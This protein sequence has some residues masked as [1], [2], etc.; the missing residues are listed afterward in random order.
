MFIFILY[1]ASQFSTQYKDFL[2]SP[3]SESLF[4][5]LTRGN[6]SI[7]DFANDPIVLWFWRSNTGNPEVDSLLKKIHME[8][9]F[10][11]SAVLRWEAKETNDYETKLNKL[12]LAAYLDPSAIENFL[13]YIVLAAEYRKFD[14][15]QTAFSLPVFSDLR[16]QLFIITNAVLL[17]L[18][19]IFM[20]GVVYILAKMVYYLRVL[21]HRI[22]PLNHNRIKGLLAFLI[23][24]IP[25]LVLRHLYLIFVCYSIVLIFVFNSKE[26][27]WLR[28]NII[29]LLLVSVFA[30]PLVPFISFLKKYDRNYQLYEIVRYDSDIT[31][32]ADNHDEKKLLAYGLKRRGEFEKAL[33]LYEDLYYGNMQDFDVTNNLAN[34][35]FLYDENALAETLYLNALRLQ[36]RGEP[37][38]N[39]GLLK[40]KNI[41]Y[42]E[43][44]K[45]MEEARKRNFSSPLKEPVDITPRNADLYKIIRSKDFKLFGIV[46]PIYL[47]P[48]LIILFLTFLP[49]AFSRPFYCKACDRPICEKC[50][51]EIEG[52][53]L[54]EDCFKTFKSAKSVEVE[55]SL[56]DLADR[57][58]KKLHKYISYTVNAIIPGAGLVFL[59]KHLLG[60]I[61]VFFV[62]LGYV[63]LLFPK[64][65]IIPAGWVSLQIH[66]VLLLIAG[67]IAIVLYLFSFSLIRSIHAD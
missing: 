42:L 66:S 60:L 33:S 12:N 41:E 49:F 36:D 14:H 11:L 32:R 47:I 46:E 54:C 67:L 2:N 26:K 63:P 40:L 25:V 6:Y 62:M 28:F 19:T 1:L 58:R 44:S 30:S 16:S 59:G 50:L 24:L 9:N 8:K 53:M 23:L 27:N 18:I 3:R 5:D 22:D 55:R 13:S 31:F 10:Y 65:F 20:C 45:Y 39:L 37:Y 21:S 61:I 51:K 38:F 64:L 52:D 56:R 4:I 35:Y 57:R 17:L 7:S 34:L 48:L 43:S 29:V 15:L